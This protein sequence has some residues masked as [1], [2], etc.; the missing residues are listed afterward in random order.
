[1]S[2]SNPNLASKANDYVFLECIGAMQ[3]KTNSLLKSRA[4]NVVL[5]SSTKWEKDVFLLL[6]GIRHSIGCVI[7]RF[8]VC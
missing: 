2:L 6:Q 5:F 1:V 3:Q 4:F 7:E 8:H